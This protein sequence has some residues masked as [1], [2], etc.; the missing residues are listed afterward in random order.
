[1]T[2]IYFARPSA[3]RPRVPISTTIDRPQLL[4][5]RQ[6]KDGWN[7]R[8]SEADEWE[9]G[10]RRETEDI[11]ET[12]RGTSARERRIQTEIPSVINFLLPQLHAAAA[13]QRPPSP[14]VVVYLFLSRSGRSVRLGSR[15]QVGRFFCLDLGLG[16]GGQIGR[17][18]SGRHYNNIRFFY[19]P[20]LT[21]AVSL[22]CVYVLCVCFVCVCVCLMCTYS[23][24]P[25]FPLSLVS[26]IAV[27][28]L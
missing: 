17:L 25:F 2:S 6:E 8:Q 5:Q 18:A 27:C 16:L 23:P 12:E 10:S 3:R 22:F 24:V 14:K 13:A 28:S 15:I 9:L 19:L 11:S 4:R 7:G 1:M 20:I 26:Q 21:E